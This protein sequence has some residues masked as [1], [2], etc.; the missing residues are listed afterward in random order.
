MQTDNGFSVRE[1]LLSWISGEFVSVTIPSSVQTPFGSSDQAVLMLR[2]SDPAKAQAQL[3]RAINWIQ[4]RLAGEKQML[5]IADA[6]KVPVKGFRNVTHPMIMMMLRPC[7][8]VWNNWLVFGTSEDCVAEVINTY[9][10][11]AE[12]I[13]S[14][15]RF[16]A[17]GLPTTGP[18]YSASYS[19]LDNLAAE[20]TQASVMMGMIGAFVPNQPETKP[21][22]AWF[23]MFGRLGPTF[24]ELN[25]FSSSSSVVTME[26]DGWSGTRVMVYKTKDQ[27]A[28][29]TSGG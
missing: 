14:N 4:D 27:I 7:V 23:N 5:M 13:K 10:G 21:V 3:D 25:F 15:P 29:K 17:E 2:V 26:K 1:D 20:M 19:D 24:M 28:A 6:Q 11:D 18:V 9:S 12:S 8:G 22:R 16:A